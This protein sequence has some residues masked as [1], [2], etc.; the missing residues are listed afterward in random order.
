MNKSNLIRKFTHLAPKVVFA[1]ASFLSANTLGWAAE[2]SPPPDP[3]LAGKYHFS[4][5][6]EVGSELVLRTNGQFQYV[7]SYGAHD[8]HAHGCWLRGGPSVWLIAA[9]PSQ[10]THMELRREVSRDGSYT[11][12][13]MMPVPLTYA[14]AGAVAN[15]V[16]V[17]MPRAF[18]GAPVWVEYADGQT[19]RQTLTIDGT[20]SA[21]VP[22]MSSVKR[23][24]VGLPKD[25][26]PRFWFDNAEPPR[27][28]FLVKVDSPAL[29]SFERKPL[30]VSDTSEPPK[31]K[32]NGVFPGTYTRQAV[33]H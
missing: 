25:A 12:Q 32:S 22:D 33:A 4:G 2:C 30:V 29:S 7:L 19:Q 24:G 14:E 23:I 5:A 1:V 15:T 28:L 8:E 17:A 13:S 20:A 16:V 26:S 31:L 3:S 6:S 27:R 10:D 9:P 11:P 21:H 18:A